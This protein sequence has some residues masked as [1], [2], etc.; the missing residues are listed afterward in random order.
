MHNETEDEIERYYRNHPDEARKQIDEH[1]TARGSDIARR[2]LGVP[3]GDA[4][5]LAK[6]RELA[7]RLPD[8]HDTEACGDEYLT[9]AEVDAIH[10]LRRLLTARG[11]GE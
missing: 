11:E 10:A 1:P 6:A 7:A 3:H 2:A 5:T 8:E 9:T 4:A